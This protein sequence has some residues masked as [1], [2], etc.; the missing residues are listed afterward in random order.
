MR[1]NIYEEELT[2]RFELLTKNAGGEAYFGL[3]FYL[4][5][6]VTVYDTDPYN[7]SHPE[8]VRGPFQHG[9]DDDDSA[10]VTFWSKDRMKLVELL[11]SALEMVR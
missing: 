10:A 11:E 7:G 2:E 3:R 6:P 8:Q 4:E 1:I 9:P 5:L